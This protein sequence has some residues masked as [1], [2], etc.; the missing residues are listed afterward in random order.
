MKTIF[1][2]SMLSALLAFSPLALRAQTITPNTTLC[3][4]VTLT[5]TSVCLTATTGVVNQT[6][7]YVDGE[8]MLVQLANSQVVAAGPSYV[9]VARAQRAG[10]LPQ[11]HA[12]GVVAWLQLTP[13]QSIVPGATGFVYS[14]QFGEVGSCVRTS[15]T[16]LPHIWPDRN[17]M[18]DCNTAGY[19]VDYAPNGLNQN[20]SPTPLALLPA[21]AALSVSSGRYM[22][23]KASAAALTLAAPTAGSMDGM[24][25]TI[26]SSTAAAHTLTA[27][28]LLENGAS[29]SPYTTATF[30]A[31]IGASITL[32]AYNGVWMVISNSNVTLS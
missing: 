23:T 22:V 13:S 1:R 32:Q 3:A 6:G 27:T 12:N 4:A 2:I 24:V 26:I 17:V 31:Y 10:T 25:I 18:R 16:Y 5:A 29:G 20:P 7:I 19:W 9:P 11:T 30:G 14:T 15:M 28:S 21:S 8:M